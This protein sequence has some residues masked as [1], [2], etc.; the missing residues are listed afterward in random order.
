[1]PHRC[2]VVAM[3]FHCSIGH[4]HAKEGHYQDALQQ[5]RVQHPK[6]CTPGNLPDSHGRALTNHGP[7]DQQLT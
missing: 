1:M 4:F 3:S 6:Q 5:C 7:Q 2:Y